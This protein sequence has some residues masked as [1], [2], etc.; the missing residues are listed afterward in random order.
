MKQMMQ[1]SSFFDLHLRFL[2]MVEDEVITFYPKIPSSLLKSSLG[3]YSS[4]SVWLPLAEESLKSLVLLSLELVW[5]FK[6]SSWSST[7]LSKACFLCEVL[8]ILC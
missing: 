2:D 8:G 5:F 4:R 6:I 3:A 1:S 7:K